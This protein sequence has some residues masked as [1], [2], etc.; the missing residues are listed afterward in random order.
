VVDRRW[1]GAGWWRSYVG[2]Y[3]SEKDYRDLKIERRSGEMERGSYAEKIG[4]SDSGNRGEEKRSRREGRW[5]RSVR[6]V[7]VEGVRSVMGVSVDVGSTGERVGIP[8]TGRRE[9]A[10]KGVLWV[11]NSNIQHLVDRRWEVAAYDRRWEARMKRGGK[12]R[13]I[14]ELAEGEDGGQGSGC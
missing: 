12:I 4:G 9:V 2:C 14:R 11:G 13:D 5:K 1:G 7:G 6:E 3:E 10:Q 8:G